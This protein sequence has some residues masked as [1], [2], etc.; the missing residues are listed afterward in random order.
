M[1]YKGITILG[2]SISLLVF[3]GCPSNSS[4]GESN[5]TKYALLDVTSTVSLSGK[6]AE[7]SGLAQYNNGLWTHND[8]G[9]RS[10]L[11]QI[12]P[13]N[14]KVEKSIK[15][16]EIKNRDWEEI[17]TDNEY[18]YIGD[19]GN[20]EGDRKK[21]RVNKMAIS[22]L[23]ID[24]TQTEIEPEKIKFNYPEIPPKLKN[25]NHNFDAEAFLPTEETIFIFSKNW[26]N[27]QCD[28]WTI[29]NKDGEWIAKRISSFD[30]DGLITSATFLEDQSKVVLL[31]Y[32]KGSLPR[33][34]IWVLSNFT[35]G[36]FFSGDKQR[37]NLDTFGQSE[38][39][40]ATG[41]KALAITS[42]GGKTSPAKFFNVTLP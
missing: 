38:A 6:V 16:N 28:L 3:L 25:N 13:D 23:D 24:S 12:N 10:I 32:N 26:G 20:N 11:F 30:T 36:D 27:Q 40:V 31:G 35:E 34:F 29:P 21:L 37:Y 2:V 17:A 19:I 8:N 41:P 5:K 15:F 22:I 18:L 33:P 14:G 9:N 4:D 39:I 7:T 42:E 1:F